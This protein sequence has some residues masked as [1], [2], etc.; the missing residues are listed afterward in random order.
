MGLLGLSSQRVE[1]VTPVQADF[2]RNRTI[3]R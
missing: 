2:L 3:S 1:D